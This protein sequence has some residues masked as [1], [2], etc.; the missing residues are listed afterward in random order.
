[1]NG[2]GAQSLDQ[3]LQTELFPN[4]GDFYIKSCIFV[5]AIQAIY[6]MSLTGIDDVKEQVLRVLTKVR[7][8]RES[9]CADLFHL[10]IK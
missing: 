10:P 3:V 6:R 2:L 8:E 9:L 7:D 5:V 4:T 1:M